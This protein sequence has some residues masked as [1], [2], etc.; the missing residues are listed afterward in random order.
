ML[1]RREWRKEKRRSHKTSLPR[2]W[3]ISSLWKQPVLINQSSISSKN[4]SRCRPNNPPFLFSIPNDKLRFAMKTRPPVFQLLSP[5][6]SL[7]LGFVHPPESIVLDISCPVSAPTPSD[8]GS[9]HE[10]NSPIGITLKALSIAK[11]RFLCMLLSSF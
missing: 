11:F 1:R 5:T 3:M 9:V 2:V 7:R 6:H 4:P 8:S 10:P